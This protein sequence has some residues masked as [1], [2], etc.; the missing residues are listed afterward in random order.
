MYLCVFVGLYSILVACIARAATNRN[1]LIQKKRSIRFDFGNY[2]DTSGAWCSA[3]ECR[4]N[5]QTRVKTCI[6][7][8]IWRNR[9]V[10]SRSQTCRG[11]FAGDAARA[12]DLI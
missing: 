4:N 8:A 3:K 9:L 2:G 6:K 10:S 12:R 5:K 7:V 1:S 11:I